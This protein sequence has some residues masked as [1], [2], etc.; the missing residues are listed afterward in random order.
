[1]YVAPHDTTDAVHGQNSRSYWP[2]K[3]AAL[4][5]LKRLF[6]RSEIT[7]A[8]A[9]NTAGQ[10]GR[11]IKAAGHQGDRE[12]ARGISTRRW[13]FQIGHLIFPRIT[14]YISQRN[15]TMQVNNLLL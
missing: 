11:D 14:G 3:L 6:I 1:M 4:S 8:C 13:S 2:G 9:D 15:M 7:D 5:P 12:A 10:T